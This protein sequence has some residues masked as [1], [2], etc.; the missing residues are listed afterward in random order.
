M[1]V[2]IAWA[3]SSFI[4]SKASPFVSERESS[5]FIAPKTSAGARARVGCDAQPPR[6]ASATRTPTVPTMC[7]M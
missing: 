2:P 4:A 5:A 7:R 6:N 3:S 1:V